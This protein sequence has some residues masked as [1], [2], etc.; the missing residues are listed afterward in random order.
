MGG[1]SE[2]FSGSKRPDRWHMNLSPCPYMRSAS[3]MSLSGFNMGSGRHGDGSML[4]YMSIAPSR[5]AEFLPTVRKLDAW[6]S[7]FRLVNQRIGFL[8]FAAGT[9]SRGVWHG[10][11]VS[12]YGER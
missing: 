4:P 12:G 3:L 8:R 5:R 7:R 1:A 11:K 10:G 6:L 2:Y 9:D